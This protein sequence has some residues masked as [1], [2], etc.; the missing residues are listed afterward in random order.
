MSD[1][2]R[3]GLRDREKGYQSKG[4]LLESW[5]LKLTY[6][7]SE[8]D[9]LA[10]ILLKLWTYAVIEDWKPD[11]GMLFVE[12]VEFFIPYEFIKYLKKTKLKLCHKVRV[13]L[14]TLPYICLS[15]M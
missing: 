10:K 3:S 8:I 13:I 9:Q 7:I 14:V 6:F 4:I 2:Y 12:N 1:R 5:F 11:Y 15:A